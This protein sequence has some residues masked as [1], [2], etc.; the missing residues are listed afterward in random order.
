LKQVKA[1]G[2]KR[3]GEDCIPSGEDEERWKQ[4]FDM[5]ILNWTNSSLETKVSA[6]NSNC[7]NE[8]VNER[9]FVAKMKAKLLLI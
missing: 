2:G 8:C 1:I 5:D 3:V 9:K 4:I 6:I 7:W